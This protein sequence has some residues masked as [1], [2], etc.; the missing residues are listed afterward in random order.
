M[1]Y[2]YEWITVNNRVLTPGSVDMETVHIVY[3]LWKMTDRVLGQKYLFSAKNT[4]ISFTF[5]LIGY[6]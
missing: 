3:S 5:H 2:K 1:E 6:V 4:V